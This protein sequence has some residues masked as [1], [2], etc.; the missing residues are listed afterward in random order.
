MD[1][2]F[3]PRDRRVPVPPAEDVDHS[4]VGPSDVDDESDDDFAHADASAASGRQSAFDRKLMEVMN[5]RKT[6]LSPSTDSKLLEMVDKLEHGALQD[7]GMLGD[8]LPGASR[9]LAL[10]RARAAPPL[11]AHS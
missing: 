3:S 5:E 7:L 9:A 4:A 11:A 6:I 1:D 2:A 8:P 10:R